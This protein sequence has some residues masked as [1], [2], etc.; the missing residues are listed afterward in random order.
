M[1]KAGESSSAPPLLSRSAGSK[2]TRLLKFTVPKMLIVKVTSDH[3]L[4]E[5][6]GSV[7]VLSQPNNVRQQPARGPVTPGPVTPAVLQPP[8]PPLVSPAGP[9]SS[10]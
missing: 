3:Q 4:A 6:R 5:F 1:M 2:P 10:P 8:R 7:A 9:R